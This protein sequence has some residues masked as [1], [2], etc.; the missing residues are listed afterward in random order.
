MDDNEKVAEM[1]YSQFR[2]KERVPISDIDDYVLLDTNYVFRKRPL[3]ILQRSR[4]KITTAVNN[5]KIPQRITGKF[6]DRDIKTKQALIW[7]ISFAD[8]EYRSESADGPDVGVQNLIKEVKESKKKST[9]KNQNKTD[10]PSSTR[11][12]EQEDTI[13]K[14]VKKTKENKGNGNKRG[15]DKEIVNEK[16][17]KRQKGA[18]CNINTNING[19]TPL[20][21]TEIDEGANEP[22]YGSLTHEQKDEGE[23]KKDTR[24][25][26]IRQSS[27]TDKFKVLK[28][29]KEMNASKV[30]KQE[31]HKRKKSK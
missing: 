4:K 28:R 2:G 12:E 10:M 24:I 17:L 16:H 20:L 13:E 25:K 23:V 14:E 11:T 27:L 3:D 29:P 19:A 22:K 26:A 30:H 21:V 6:P 31:G 5:L 8:E 7:Y 9:K 15:L 18:F 1:I